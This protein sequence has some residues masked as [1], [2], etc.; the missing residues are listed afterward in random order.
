MNGLTKTVKCVIAGLGRIGS[1]LE[2]DPLREK[3][4]SHAGAVWAHPQALLAAG[5]DPVPERREEFEA[6]WN[7][8]R[9]YEDPLEMLRIEKPD[10]FHIASWTD[11]HPSLLT[12]AMGEGIPV[13]ICEKPLA[14]SLKAVRPLIRKTH[15]SSCRVVMN[16][17]RRFSRDYRSV[18]EII[19]EKRF[20]EL[21]SVSG[22]L[23]MGLT[24]SP[25]AVLYHDGTHMIDIIRFLTGEDIAIKRVCGS[26]E[27]KGGDLHI[28]AQAGSTAVDLDI[29]GGRDYLLFELDL[30]FSS[31]RIRIGNGIYELWESEES[32]YYTGFKSLSKKQDG[33]EGRTGYFAGMMEHAVDLAEN[34]E[35]QSESTLEDGL[36]VLKIIA[37]ILK[38]KR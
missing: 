29:S 12:A 10:I 24:R 25:R 13:I 17:E 31:G 16:H 18:R 33:W 23:Y 38:K 28:L 9:T 4:A 1:T 35:R 6:D 26:P 8:V 15:N 21:L 19:R 11:S 2:K 30:T 3:P 7:G 37:A 14:N 20:G 34:P 22:K 5:A 36:A 27:V 32:P